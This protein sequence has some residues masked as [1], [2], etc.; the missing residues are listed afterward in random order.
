MFHKAMQDM[1]G[2]DVLTGE[3]RIGA[4]EDIYFDAEWGDVRY[5]AVS[6]GKGA[7]GMPMYVAAVPDADEWH[8][9]SPLDDDA[10]DASVCSSSDVVGFRVASRDGPAGWVADLLVDDDR[11]QIE[12]MVVQLDAP[13]APGD[14]LV[15]LTWLWGIDKERRM[16]IVGCSDAELRGAPLY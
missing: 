3:G 8:A 9:D 6:T 7:S 14:R 2:G 15:P 11:W 13:D 4:L 10:G 16:V 5:L 1:R 12:Y